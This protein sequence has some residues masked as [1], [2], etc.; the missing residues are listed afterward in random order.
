MQYEQRWCDAQR[1]RLRNPWTK[2]YTKQGQGQID[3]D[4]KL[5]VRESPREGL[6]NP[7]RSVS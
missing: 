2:S 3:S 1:K 6:H 4:L 7:R 5:F